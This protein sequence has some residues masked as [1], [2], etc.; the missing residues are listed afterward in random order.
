M[1]LVPILV[2]LMLPAVGEVSLPAWC[3]ALV[4]GDDD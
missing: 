4:S 1:E 2:M 3:A